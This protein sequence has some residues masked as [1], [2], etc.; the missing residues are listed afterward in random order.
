MIVPALENAGFFYIIPIGP[1]WDF[2]ILISYFICNCLCECGRNAFVIRSLRATIL[3]CCA[4]IWES[5]NNNSNTRT[6]THTHACVRCANRWTCT[7]QVNKIVKPHVENVIGFIIIDKF[8]LF[9]CFILL[10]FAWV[11]NFELLV[12]KKPNRHLNVATG[13]KSFDWKL[14]T[15]SHW[16]GPDGESFKYTIFIEFDWYSAMESSNTRLLHSKVITRLAPIDACF[17]TIVVIVH[18][19]KD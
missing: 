11:F 15:Q 6:H 9:F 7:L 2:R 14:W 16:L 3:C 13:D 17:I 4:C 5:E 10:F 12:K 1:E 19:A 18:A 8:Q